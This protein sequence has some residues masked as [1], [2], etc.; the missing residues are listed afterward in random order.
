MDDVDALVETGA[1]LLDECYGSDEWMDLIDVDRLNMSNGCDCVL[2]QLFDGYKAGATALGVQDPGFSHVAARSCGFLKSAIAGYSR[3]N[4]AW[5]E[6][7][8]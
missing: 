3:L 8:R 7:L 2:G 6:F 1:A 4:V 5:R